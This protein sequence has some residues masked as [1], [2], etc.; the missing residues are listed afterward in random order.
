LGRVP[1]WRKSVAWRA[2]SAA[3]AGG[4]AGKSQ[5]RLPP[6][7]TPPVSSDGTA[8][9][10]APRNRPQQ[11]FPAAPATA[12]STSYSVVLDQNSQLYALEVPPYCATFHLCSGPTK[13]AVV[14]AVVCVVFGPDIPHPF[15]LF[16]LR[17]KCAERA[18]M[19]E[20]LENFWSER[21]DLN[22]GPPVPQTGA[23]AELAMPR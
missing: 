9:R 4:A 8:F 5:A 6:A 1:V 23:L 19:L 10:S 21:R 14:S 3:A 11:P 13:T 7:A 17:V 15:P 2:R 20:L 22:S 16:P 12:A 18:K